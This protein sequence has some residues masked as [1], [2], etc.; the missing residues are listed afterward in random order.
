MIFEFTYTECTSAGPFKKETGFKVKSVR[1]YK[2]AAGSSDSH[3]TLFNAFDTEDGQGNLIRETLDE[4]VLHSSKVDAATT[5]L[6]GYSAPL[7]SPFSSPEEFAEIL[8]V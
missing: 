7:V 4:I 3:E 5:R 6:G 8:D 1:L 2:L